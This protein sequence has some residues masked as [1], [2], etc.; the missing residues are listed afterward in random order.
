MQNKYWYLNRQLELLELATI[1]LKLMHAINKLNSVSVFEVNDNDDTK[2]KLRA[3]N[4]PPDEIKKCNSN[5]VLFFPG[6]LNKS[7]SNSETSLLYHTFPRSLRSN[8]YSM[9]LNE[10]SPVVTHDHVIR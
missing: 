5:H 4:K 10:D 9:S 7:Y 2:A 3:T 6:M 8:Y 1:A